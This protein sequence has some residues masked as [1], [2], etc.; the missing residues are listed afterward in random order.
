MS[1]ITPTE[2]NNI[3]HYR[4]DRKD[5]KKLDDEY[6]EFIGIDTV[7]TMLINI[8]AQITD[9]EL[10]KSELVDA[11]FIKNI[12]ISGDVVYKCVKISRGWRRCS[13]YVFLQI[14]NRNKGPARAVVFVTDTIHHSAICFGTTPREREAQEFL[15][16]YLKD[17]ENLLADLTL[18]KK[19]HGTERSAFDLL[20]NI[21]H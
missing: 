13:A 10:K 5:I 7:Q 6:I 17:K 16:T 12:G 11:A 3:F 15:D 14:S 21:Q 1:L 9:A 2:N 4:S 19:S 20:K 8:R 18:L